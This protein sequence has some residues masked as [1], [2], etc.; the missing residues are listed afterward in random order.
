MP[1]QQVA[2]SHFPNTL[3][4]KFE[5]ATVAH[6]QGKLKEAERIYA[7]ILREQPSHFDALHRLGIVAAQ[8][9]Q[10]ERAVEFFRKAIR[11]NDR[12]ASVHRNLGNALLELGMPND[13]IFAYESAIAL[14]PDD[15]DSYS[16]CGL[17]L[18]ELKRFKDAIEYFDRA[19][20]LMP[21]FA[22]AHYHRGLSLQKLERFPE[23]LECYD[24][25][26][27]IKPDFVEAYSN[28]GGTLRRLGRVKD[29]LASYD[30]V[31]ALRPRS[32][33]GY[34]NR[35][36]ALQDL[37][38][39]EEALGEFDK[40]IE[41]K[42]DFAEAHSNRGNVL[43]KLERPDEALSSFDKA[44]AL[45]PDFA[46]AYTNRGN[47]LKE[48]GQLQRSRDDYE[49]F[50]QF[51]SDVAGVYLNLSHLKIFSPG[52]P[53]LKAMESLAANTHALSKCDRLQL[54]FALGK[55]Y[56][57]L[58]DYERS[59]AHF[60]AGNAA[61][62][63]MTSYDEKSVFDFFERIESL[64]TPELI[65]AKISSGYDSPVPIFVIGMVRSGTTLVEQIVASHPM[66]HGAGELRTLSE[67]VNSFRAPTGKGIRYPEIISAAD[68][69]V[70]QQLGERY[71]G[72]L[73]ARAPEADRVTDKMPGNFYYAGLIHL[74]LPNAKIIH[75][76]RDPV[77]TCISCFSYLFS[78]EQN[79][80]YNLA[81]LGRYYKRYLR[82][83]AHWH[84]I[85]PAGRILD[86]QYEAVVA[87]LEGQA[88]R[89]LD[90]CGLPWDHRCLAFHKTQRPIRTTSAVQVRQPIYKSAIGRWRG[91]E[92]LLGPLLLELG[93]ID[94]YRPS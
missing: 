17:A 55:A 40:A 10:T 70:L 87:D 67:V 34:V 2:Q 68:R 64:F 38:R 86:V 52:D 54:D 13:A 45:K 29:A 72:S 53:H 84:R 69:S 25:A 81:E 35:G 76:V 88:R 15:A 92:E 71:V 18:Q 90:H 94:R 51:N 82:L 63:A 79:Y 39:F 65:Q 61:K 19:I 85:L 4:A 21:V 78:E 6:K 14:S 11:L 80:T 60:V 48:L 59:F 46:E 33:D 9:R 49:R 93:T 62:R 73:R 42:P 5:E 58:K 41:L 74:A 44:I 8:T 32:A 24:R 37:G 47:V 75:T 3:E 83:M 89:I 16:G 36:N 57:D 1:E 28:R 27:A 22:E 20:A 43:K 66:V 31:I 56:A 50:L 30:E 91:Y 12:V 77:D 23:A 7:D 26:L